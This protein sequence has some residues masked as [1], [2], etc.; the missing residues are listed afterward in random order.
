MIALLAEPHDGLMTIVERSFDRECKRCPSSRSLALVFH[1]RALLQQLLSHCS[2]RWKPSLIPCAVFNYSLSTVCFLH[3]VTSVCIT[4]FGDF[5]SIFDLDF[6]EFFG[7][8]VAQF[9]V[10]DIN[11]LFVKVGNGT[12]DR[13][14]DRRTPLSI[15]SVRRRQCLMGHNNRS[16]NAEYSY[17]ATEQKKNTRDSLLL[18]VAL[19]T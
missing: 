6:V 18:W 1:N 9:P 10:S 7:H 2:V 19:Q 8:L 3:I 12:T 14:T 4:I 17:V 15:A 16:R 5:F 13:Q 11:I